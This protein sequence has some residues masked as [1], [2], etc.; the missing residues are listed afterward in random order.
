MLFHHISTIAQQQGY[1]VTK[2][3]SCAYKD[4]KPNRFD[5]ACDHG[6]ASYR[7]IA[8]QRAAHSRKTACP[9]K[10]RATC[11]QS[12]GG[13]WKF[14]VTC[15][16]HNHPPNDPNEPP[17]VKERRAYRYQL[18]KAELAKTRPPPEPLRLGV[19]PAGQARAASDPRA[20]GF[21]ASVQ[22]AAAQA[23]AAGQQAGR[24]GGQPSGVTIQPVTDA[25]QRIERSLGKIEKFESSLARIE[26]FSGRLEAIERRL[27]VIEKEWE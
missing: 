25:L 8:V 2:R 6:G 20:Q 7:S 5:L 10:A 19:L 13:Q 16:S 18:K 24:P 22:E 17:G 27:E 1:K 15:G 11:M 4:G 14:V 23:G 21:M 26:A 12:L 9:W 3:R